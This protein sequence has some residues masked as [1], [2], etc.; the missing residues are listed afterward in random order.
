MAIWLAICSSSSVKAIA[1]TASRITSHLAQR[2]YDQ[3]Y[4]GLTLSPAH[5]LRRAGLIFLPSL[6]ES[7]FEMVVET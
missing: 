5:H 1:Y 6:T 4:S 7:L 3:K 2:D